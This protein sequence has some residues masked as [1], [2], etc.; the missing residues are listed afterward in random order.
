[1][2]T[3]TPP[4]RRARGSAVNILPQRDNVA[5]T[6]PWLGTDGAASRSKLTPSPTAIASRRRVVPHAV[7]P[8]PLP[9]R[10]RGE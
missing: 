6:G 4:K 3:A 10:G 1:M 7:P 8:R 9:L 5:A 2:T